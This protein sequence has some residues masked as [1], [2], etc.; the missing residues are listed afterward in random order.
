MLH[1]GGGGGGEGGICSV[2]KVAVRDLTFANQQ[3]GDGWC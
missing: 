3:R 1:G 2:S